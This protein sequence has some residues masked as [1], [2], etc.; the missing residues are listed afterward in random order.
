MLFWPILGKMSTFPL[1]FL[2]TSLVLFKQSKTAADI[3]LYIYVIICLMSIY[4]LEYKYHDVKNFDIS[5]L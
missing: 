1:K 5:E 4:P 2:C 3:I